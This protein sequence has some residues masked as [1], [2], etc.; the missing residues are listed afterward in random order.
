MSDESKAVV[1][2]FVEHNQ[3]FGV[4]AA[5]TLPCAQRRTHTR[6]PLQ[7]VTVVYIHA[8]FALG[9]AVLLAIGLVGLHLHEE[10]RLGAFGAGGFALALA[11]TVVA[12]GGQWTYVFV[13]L[14]TRIDP[15]RFPA[16]V[17]DPR[18]LEALRP[19]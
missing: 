10:A 4:H 12:A 11:G 16:R 6:K 15:R 13:P 18:A 7:R 19:V 1:R 5:W 2:R 8:T 14:S 17:D 3:S 9:S